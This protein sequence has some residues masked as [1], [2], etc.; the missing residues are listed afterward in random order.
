M[1]R[2]LKLRKRAYNP[3]AGGAVAM[4][5]PPA[6]TPALPPYAG[7]AHS[8]QW[9][10]HPRRLAIYLRDSYRCQY[11]RC[12]LITANRS[13]ITLDHVRPRLATPERVHASSNLVTACANCNQHKGARSLEDYLAEHEGITEAQKLAVLENIQIQTALPVYVCYAVELLRRNEPVWP[14]CNT[15]SLHTRRRLCEDYLTHRCRYCTN[16]R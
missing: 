1:R 12:S 13:R 9:I 4:I 5:K 2:T 6:A 15:A 16:Q 11:C 7:S 10:T 14:T 8:A 3:R